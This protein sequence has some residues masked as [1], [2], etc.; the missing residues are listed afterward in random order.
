MVRHSRGLCK[1]NVHKYYNFYTLLFKSIYMYI[2]SL[3]SIIKQ[4]EI[5]KSMIKI[6]HVLNLNWQIELSFVPHGTQYSVIK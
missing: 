2:K 3:N 4:Y 6:S 5:R 1:K